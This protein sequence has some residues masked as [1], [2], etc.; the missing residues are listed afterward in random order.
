MLLSSL[1]STGP[2][3][4]GENDADCNSAND[5]GGNEASY[6][7]ESIPEPMESPIATPSFFAANHEGFNAEENA[8][9]DWVDDSL[10]QSLPLNRP[11]RTDQLQLYPGYSPSPATTALYGSSIEDRE[12]ASTP[13][14]PRNSARAYNGLPRRKSRYMIREL[15][16]RPNAVFIPP[17]AGPADPLER[18]KQSAPEGEAASLSAIQYALEKPSIYTGPEGDQGRNTSSPLF[19]NRRR[20]ASRAASATSG[21]S[22]T[23]ASSRRSGRS[24]LSVLSSGSQTTPDNKPAGIRKKQTSVGRGGK[25]RSSASN[26]RIFCCT[27]CCDKFKSKFDWMRHEKSLHLQL[28]NW[29]CAPYGGS[30]ILPATGRAHCAYCNQL[31][32]TQDHL[33]QHNHGFCEQQ[34]TRTFRRKDHLLQHLRLFHRLDTMPLIDDWKRSFTN[35][36][37]RCGF[38][39]GRMSN[40]DERADHLTFHFRKGCTMAHWKGDHEFPAEIAAQV[41]HS[42]PPYLLDFESRSFVPFSATNGVVNDHLSQMLSRATFEVPA[43]PQM[44]PEAPEAELQPVQEVQLDS[45]TEV[46]TRHLSHYAQRMMSSGITPTDEMFQSEARRLLFDSEDQWNQTIADNLEWLAQFRGEQSGNLQVPEQA[47]APMDP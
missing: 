12:S 24:S 39:G 46:L 37:S 13:P 10:S 2:L 32:P 3:H 43:G 7:F 25:K 44:A 27:F 23:S 40:W 16:Q 34:Q 33:D 6:P 45:Y 4:F 41:T 38:C 28:E 29:A 1:D 15:D 18:W 35:F 26:A 8:R 21:E 5:F 47:P 42:V 19:Q 36:S 20:S 30:V 22:A 31:D 11:S 14:L 9:S 17:H